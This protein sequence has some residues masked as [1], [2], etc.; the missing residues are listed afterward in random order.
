MQGAVSEHVGA[1]GACGCEVIEVRRRAELEGLDG[2][3]VPG[4]ESTAIGRLIQRDSLGQAIKEKLAEGMGFWGTCAGLILAAQE[5]DGSDQPGLGIM[6]I[7]AKRNAFGRQRESFEADLDIPVLGRQPFRGVF[8][9]APYL[10][11]RGPAVELL[12]K[13]AEKGVLARQGKILVSAFHPELT[14]DT[15]LHAYFLRML[16]G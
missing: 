15:R 1:L 5:I 3:I 14:P 12:A 13:F 11:P 9:R 10:E 7:R 8:I 6:S 2:L 16:A 4:G